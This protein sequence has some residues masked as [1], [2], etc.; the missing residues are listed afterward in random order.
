MTN[1]LKQLESDLQKELDKARA[2]SSTN[3]NFNY[4]YSY[5]I[6]YALNLIKSKL[7]EI[8]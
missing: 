5:G 3:D 4:A 2:L 1:E 8:I 7:N 6:E